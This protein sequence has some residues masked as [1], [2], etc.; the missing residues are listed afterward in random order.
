VG[1]ELRAHWQ[2]AVSTISENQPTHAKRRSSRQALESALLTFLTVVHVARSPPLPSGSQ[3]PLRCSIAAARRC[4]PQPSGA[5]KKLGSVEKP[6][7][8]YTAGSCPADLCGTVVGSKAGDSMPVVERALE[9][10]VFLAPGSRVIRPP[11]ERTYPHL[12]TFRRHLV[13]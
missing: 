12:Q 8:P 6:T 4:Q 7:P 11:V 9:V 1:N 5:R 13:P 3:L 10:V 2:T